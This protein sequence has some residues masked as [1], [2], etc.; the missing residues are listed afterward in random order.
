MVLPREAEVTNARRLLALVGLGYVAVQLLAFSIGR[1]PGWDEAIYLSQITPGAEP[2]PF[3]AFRARGITLLVAPVLQLGGSTQDVR[4]FL[5]VASGAA[6][7]GAMWT[8]T[9]I[10]GYGA[11]AAALLFAGS[12]PALFYGSEVMPN[13]WA[14]FPTI[15]AT[16]FLARRLVGL[17]RRT[18][19]LLAGTMVALT[20]LIRPPDA[21][22]LAL[23]LV[24]VPIL[25]GRGSIAWSAIVL[26]GLAAGW[27]PWLVEMGT[28]YGGPAAALST[29]ADVGGAARGSFVDG[30]LQY[31]ALSDGPTMGPVADPRV[32]RSGLLW[33]VGLA[34]LVAL[35][36]HAARR[37]G[38]LAA[39]A[40]PFLGAPA[41]AAIY[42]GF[43]SAQ[44]PRFL[45][46]AL[47]AFCLPAGLG[48]VEALRGPGRRRGLTAPAF[49]ARTTAIVL[50]G[51]WAVSQVTVA[52]KIEN[53]IS[54]GR[55]SAERAGREVGR[56]AGEAPCRLF[57]S[58]SY[59][60]VGYAGGCGAAPLADVPRRWERRAT[61]LL[62]DGIRPFLV[63]RDGEPVVPPAGA[64]LVR[65][66]AV[67]GD[68]RW[69]IYGM[70]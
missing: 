70:A 20:A 32:P 55:E 6:L 11:P 18:D 45:L 21:T 27:A 17:G 57:S 13:L 7:I 29:A 64:E 49:A 22:A 67:G 63:Y 8:W 37:R 23:A 65:T 30:I 28:R 42:L 61:G 44:A 25:V 40:I 50:T 9:R 33:L 59:P 14:A 38:T 19:E 5:A 47:G 51:A 12:W 69:F 35:G 2:L 60:M 54:P 48:L 52:L 56:I 68:R 3:A 1:S 4:L 43:T 58:A 10:I 41:L 39:L 53:A 26:L 16:A 62:R 46:P 34:V 15:A 66:V 31:A 24:I 36:L